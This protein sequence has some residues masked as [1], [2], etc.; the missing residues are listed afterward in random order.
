[1]ENA[2]YVGRVGALAVA[3]G[4][5]AGALVLSG[6]AWATPA[7]TD[8]SSSVAPAKQ[9]DKSSDSTKPPRARTDDDADAGGNSGADEPPA[10]DEAGPDA[11]EDDD[12]DDA[13]SK[14][15]RKSMSS[16][17]SADADTAGAAD[18]APDD[19]P[20]GD[21]ESA[22]EDE[23]ADGDGSTEPAAPAA[24][25]D[26]AAPAAETEPTTVNAPAP[27]PPVEAEAEAEAV[28][29][30]Q[31]LFAPQ[32][33]SRSVDGPAAPV[34]SP[35][36]W[37]VLAFARRQFD[38]PRTE[39]EK[40]GAADGTSSLVEPDA[41]DSDSTPGRSA[42]PVVV[43]PDGTVY[44][45][46]YDVDPVTN[47]PTATRVSIIDRDGTVISTTGPIAGVPVEQARA[48]VRPD[49]S[50]V[51]TTHRTSTN[52]T[53]VSIVDSSGQVRRLGSVIGQPSGPLEAA[54]DG[55]IYLQTFQFPTGL[56]YPGDRLV[57]ISPTNRL[58][59]YQVGRAGS[60]VTFAPDGTAYLTATSL[61]GTQSVLAVSSSGTPRRLLLPRSDLLDEVLIG[62]DGRGYL[63]V[64]RTFFG[65]TSTRVYTFTGTTR[66]ARDIVGAPVGRKAV[67]AD[68]VYQATY[69]AVT[70]RSFVSKITATT[71]ET[72]D[73]IDGSVINTIAVT[74]GGTVYVSVRNQATQTDSVAVVSPD[75][76]VETVAIPGTITLVS[77]PESGST[78]GY[79]V[80]PDIGDHGYVAYTVGGATYLAVINPDGTIDRTV[81]LP[82]EASVDT[83][84]I[85]G[86]DGAPYQVIEYENGVGPGAAY[87]VI[88]LSN[89]AVSAP[90]PG[91][92]LLPNFPLLQFGPDGVAYLAT[93]ESGQNPAFHIVGFDAAGDVVSSL[94]ASGFLV[95]QQLNHVFAQAALAFGA[96][97]TAYATFS[98]QD[99]G[100]WALTPDGGTQVLDLDLSPGATVDP[101]AF[102]PDGT[103]Y[104]TV[105]EF[106]DGAWATTVRTFTPLTS[107]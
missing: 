56:G 94:D 44:Q 37:A 47:A 48:V 57:R 107:L 42:G 96:D 29:V 14:K 61:F 67:T 12:I 43:G 70:G 34:E 32:A 87:A 92:R 99:A 81:A 77:R 71:I 58:R 88:T 79:V 28:S 49:G 24:S 40:S 104:L 97:G 84:V 78:S 75:G 26:I 74:P 101:V 50:L 7:G 68:G 8:S 85:Y 89:D 83:T 53:V 21:D 19:A 54:P 76:T 90:Q 80:D 105:S 91:T 11:S 23:Q 16:K 86:P 63:T 15:T 102:G 93:Q 45:V 10:G 62:A 25:D 20:V 31:R 33:P 36:L 18:D 35:L 1:M 4:V 95:P 98:G 41:A 27:Q 64:E 46:T 66:T 17:L 9:T 103:A 13:A 38:R 69:D 106:V 5:G 55:S 22:A 52:T 73:P 3:M 60:A 100:V 72:S 51:L 30:W 82:A 39:I 59:T 65:R 2:G 6:T